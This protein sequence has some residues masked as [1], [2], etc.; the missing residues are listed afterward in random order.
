MSA[1]TSASRGWATHVDEL[2]CPDCGGGLT[3]TGAEEVRDPAITC[4]RCHKRFPVI[5]GIP[6]FATYLQDQAETA[7]SFGFAWKAFWTGSFDKKSIFGLKTAETKRHVLSCFG[8]DE[9]QL[10]GAKMLDA[11]T[12]SGRI[13]MALRDARCVIYG[14]DIHKSLDLVKDAIA[15]ESVRI[16]QADLMKLPFEDGSFDFVWS[17]GVIH[18]TPNTASAFAALARKVKP[19]GRMFISV[20]SIARHHYRV[21]RH[22]L[23]FAPK[24]PTWATYALASFIAVP[25][26]V[27]FNG[28][29]LLVRTTR[30]NQPPPYSVMGFSIEDIE[31][32]SYRSILLNL[33]DQLHPKYQHE[34]S[35][36]EVAQWFARN[37][38]VDV[39][40]TN[41]VGMVE[42]R[43]VKRSPG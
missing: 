20:Y 4:Q 12:G 7:S 41:V 32:K 19:G 36:E 14:V 13:P 30:G 6:H 21:F 37:G 25:L 11:G 28:I 39:V 33:F 10:S 18:H 31:H 35:V 3:A 5:R 38:F 29:L 43:G 24:L 15:S 8:I 1:S 26:F 42:M 34:H 9:R 22:L 23:P 17:S 2:S 27:G 16:C 40:P